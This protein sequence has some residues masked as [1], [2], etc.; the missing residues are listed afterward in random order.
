MQKTFNV[1]NNLG[2]WFLAFILL[3]AWGFY[4]RYFANLL[5]PMPKLVH[6]HFA[7]MGAWVI[8]LIVQPFLIKFKKNNIHR[9][10]GKLS[11]VIAP[12]AMVTSFL[13]MRS[14]YNADIAS[15]HNEVVAGTAHYTNSEILTEAASRVTIT[16]LYLAWFA[17]FYGLAIWNR[18]HVLPHSRYML[19]S[20]LLILGPT[21]DRILFFRFYA[22]Y[23]FHYELI[24]FLIQDLVIAALLIQDIKRKKRTRALAYVLAIFVIGQV[25]YFNMGGTSIYTAIVT[26]LMNPRQ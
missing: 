14:H 23:P 15:L 11:Y 17:L 13:M 25:I 4:P 2:Y 5:Q 24:P 18:K 20:A 22:A 16:M 19:A 6:L 21:V 3:V 1:Y 12:G 10:V 7:F 26:F 9:I 8:T